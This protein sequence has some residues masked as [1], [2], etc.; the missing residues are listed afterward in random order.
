M[1]LPE[2]KG[3][4]RI[5]LSNGTSVVAWYNPRSGHWLN[6]DQTF[7]IGFACWANDQVIVHIHDEGH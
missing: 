6:K 2:T 5:S 1:E 4:Y 7:E 3:F